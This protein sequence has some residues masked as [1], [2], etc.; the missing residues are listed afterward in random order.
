MAVTAALQ[1]GLASGFKAAG[2]TAGRWAG[3]KTKS[4]AVRCEWAS[5]VLIRRALQFR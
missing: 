1:A 3:E 5:P 2:P 4:S